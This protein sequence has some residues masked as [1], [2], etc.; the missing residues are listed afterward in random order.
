MIIIKNKAMSNRFG[1]LYKIKQICDDKDT[2]ILIILNNVKLLFDLQ[3]QKNKIYL[4]W[5]VN[6]IILKDKISDIET[7][8]EKLFDKKVKSN[9][10]KKNNYPD[11]LE[12]QIIKSCD[13]SS[14]ISSDN[15]ILTYEEYINKQNKYN[16][17]AQIENVFVKK[18]IINYTIKIKKIELAF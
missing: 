2:P 6:S 14:C 16:V 7:N 5:I 10:I 9:I 11:F 17:I 3:T 4:K 15:N 13:G 1:T 18:D 8:I 12:T